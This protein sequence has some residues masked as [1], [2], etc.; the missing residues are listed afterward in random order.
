MNDFKQ[1]I[2]AIEQVHQRLQA[3]AA[4]AVNRALTLRNWLIGY[5]IVE[6]EQKGYER[7]TYG[8]QLLEK[9]AATV[10]I[11]GISATN[12]KLFRQFYLAYPQ[13][14]QTVSDQLRSFFQ[15]ENQQTTIGQTVSDQLQ[16]LLPAIQNNQ[17]P[18]IPVTVPSEK[19][20]SRLSFSHLIELSKIEDLL[21]RSFYEIECIKG[22]WSVR[23]LK[24]QINSLYFERS[25]LSG[26]PE[27]LAQLV[28]QKTKPLA[29]VDIIKNIYAFEFLNISVKP[30]VEESD[31]EIALLDNLQEFIIELGNGFCFE[32]RQKRI[33][34]GDTYY[35]IDIVF[36]HRVLKCHVL[37][38]LKI[39]AFEHG[40]I[41]QLNTYLNYFKQEICEQDDN[42]PVGI[43]LVAEKDHALVKYA[44]AGMDENLFIQKYLIRLPDKEQLEHH[45]EK[46]LK[47]LQ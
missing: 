33:L 6:F 39:G 3:E 34:I 17:P 16:P 1:L 24:R 22:T 9:I 29:P 11:N 35:F 25:G 7:A 19:I 26:H 47:K 38:E 18:G 42:P 13:I 28:Q 37:I 20:I 36:Y 23:E 4:G 40:D 21:K 5:Y 15:I 41:G 46:E 44:T 30:V 45:I 43:L 10:K 2:T 14:S 32:A 8:Q 12:L 31:L 27:K